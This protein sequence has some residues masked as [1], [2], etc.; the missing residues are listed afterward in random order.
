MW[1]FFPLLKKLQRDSIVRNY[2]RFK[3]QG[4]GTEVS[5]RH[6]NRWS[7]EKRTR[8]DGKKGTKTKQEDRI[9]HWFVLLVICP[10]DCKSA[11]FTLSSGKNICHKADIKNSAGK[12]LKTVFPL[13]LFQAVEAD[14]LRER[15]H[16]CMSITLNSS[17][18]LKH[19]PSRGCIINREPCLV[20]LQ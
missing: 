1:M 7:A 8:K 13:W 2:L 6:R 14:H 11:P 12:K 9:S 18:Q 19:V 3:A 20:S 10:I 16:H 15:H 4:P 5:R 17:V